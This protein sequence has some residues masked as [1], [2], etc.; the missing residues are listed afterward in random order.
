MP[1]KRK[2][3]EL[4][5]ERMEA[6]VKIIQAYARSKELANISTERENDAKRLANV[7]SEHEHLKDIKKNYHELCENTTMDSRGRE[8]LKDGFLSMCPAAF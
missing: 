8:I 5:I 6:E 3:G 4:E 7:M 1:C 2:L